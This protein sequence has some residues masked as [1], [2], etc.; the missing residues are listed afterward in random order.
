VGKTRLAREPSGEPKRADWPPRGSSPLGP[1]HRFL[2]SLRHLLPEALPSTISRLQ[3]LRQFADTLSSRARGHRLVIGSTTRTCSTKAS[4][5]L[6]HQLAPTEVLRPGHRESRRGDTRLGQG[7]LEGRRGRA[8][9]GAGPAGGS[10][11][12]L[13]SKPRWA[14]GRS[15]A[16]QAVEA[17]RGNVLP[18]ARPGGRETNALRLPVA[19][20]A[21]QAPWSLSPRLREVLDARLGSLQPD[22][23]ALVEVLAYAE[24]ASV[25]F[26]RDAVLLVDARDC[27]ET[28]SGCGGKGRPPACYPPSPSLYGIGACP[29]SRPSAREIQRQFAAALRRPGLAGE[30]TCCEWSLPAWKLGRA[31]PP[32]PRRRSPS[33]PRLLDPALAERLGR[34]AAQAG[35][36][37]PLPTCSHSRFSGR[38]RQRSPFSL[39]STKSM[40]RPRA[41]HHSKAQHHCGLL[42]EGSS[43]EAEALLLRTERRSRIQPCETS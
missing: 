34:A 27:R 23:A 1:A 39:A 16:G 36:G 26:C 10:H 30:T 17:S 24:P 9:R 37:V 7:A 40:R 3:L 41:G 43:A 4:A 19:C 8:H 20:G 18:G 6:L 21:G 38:K 15:D 5:A 22:Q 35:G 32:A 29:L 11:G 25:S 33:S 14:G 12:Q 28:G 2:W 13:V 42:G 31:D